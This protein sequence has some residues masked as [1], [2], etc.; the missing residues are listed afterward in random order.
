MRNAMPSLAP[1][2]AEMARRHAPGIAADRR[3]DAYVAAIADLGGREAV[4]AL[5]R[6]LCDARAKDDDRPSNAPLRTS[7]IGYLRSHP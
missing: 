2:R 3:A 6:D 4:V 7:C 5:Y 1:S